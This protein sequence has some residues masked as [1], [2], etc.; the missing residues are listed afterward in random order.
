MS[1]K[2]KAADKRLSFR[3]DGKRYYV[4]GRTEAIR[5]FRK[6]QKIEELKRAGKINAG[7]NTTVSEWAHVWLETVKRPAVGDAQYLDCRSVIRAHIDPALGR[8]RLEEV[9]PLMV[10]R[11]L[12]DRA[13]FSTS[14]GKRICETL[15]Q[16][17][18]FA[19]KNRLI[20]ENPVEDVDLPAF[21]P[22]RHVSSISD[23]LRE[24]VLRTA[25][26]HAAGLYVLTMLYTGM[27]PGE[28][29]ALEWSDLD[30]DR[31]YVYVTRARKARSTKIGAPKSAAGVRPIPLNAAILP[32]LR[33]ERKRRKDED[34]QHVVFTMMS[35]DRPLTVTAERRMWESFWRAAGYETPPARKY[36]LRHTF[37]TDGQRAG[38]PINVMRE[39]GGHAD[40]KTTA[41]IYTDRS[42]EATEAAR[43]A[44]NALLGE[45]Q[46]VRVRVRRPVSRLVAAKSGKD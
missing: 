15:D 41:Q 39:L 35:C 2:K 40:I 20:S 24:D 27:R 37:F 30:L 1:A 46:S 44:M 6:Q 11:F 29:A 23:D 31:G 4:R 16:I 28:L 17:F 22:V 12:A 18:R 7:E 34:P 3:V 25:K 5:Q 8:Y 45:K 14:W 32:L 10:Q 38:V 42:V 13:H 43:D 26:E 33:A 9:T 21:V 36:A 19:K